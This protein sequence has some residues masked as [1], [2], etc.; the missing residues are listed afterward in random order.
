MSSVPTKEEMTATQS[1]VKF[2]EYK[3][4]L[5]TGTGDPLYVVKDKALEQEARVCNGCINNWLKETKQIEYVGQ[6]DWLRGPLLLYSKWCLA[7][8][9]MAT[10]K[11]EPGEILSGWTFPGTRSNRLERF[12]DR[13]VV[14]F[15]ILYDDN[16]ATNIHGQMLVFEVF[17]S[18]TMNEIGEGSRMIWVSPSHLTPSRVTLRNFLSSESKSVPDPACAVDKGIF[19]GELFESS[20]LYGYTVVGTIKPESWT[21]WVQPTLTRIAR[22]MIMCRCNDMDPQTP[23]LAENDND[24]KN[25]VSAV[26]PPG[27]DGGC[28]GACAR[29]L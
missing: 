16:P 5:I 23:S 20:P 7:Q 3:H 28:M 14:V 8:K 15:R 12:R 18:T 25:I 1:K 6:V 24:D 11:I 27:C 10:Q 13:L 29:S 4:Y 2:Q 9:K 17:N 21:G 19:I 26:L 22:N